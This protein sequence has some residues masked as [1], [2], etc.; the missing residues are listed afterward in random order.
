MQRYRLW[1]GMEAVLV[2]H[3]TN[4]TTIIQVD[5]FWTVWGGYY[6][7]RVRP[8]AN[9]LLHVYLPHPEFC[10][11]TNLLWWAYPFCS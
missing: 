7:L 4:L 5:K 1:V 3:V 8:A 6:F 9:R 11:A 10:P 2:Q